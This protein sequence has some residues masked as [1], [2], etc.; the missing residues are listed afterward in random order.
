MSE[1]ELTD[2]E[3]SFLALAI[4]GLCMRQGPPAF[5]MAAQIVQKIGLTKEL[6]HSLKSWIA[7]STTP[8]DAERRATRIGSIAAGFGELFG[9][10]GQETANDPRSGLQDKEQT[11]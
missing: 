8:E 11:Q 4:Q 3:R 7:Y 6:E 10:E 1:N 5:A 2:A 9:P